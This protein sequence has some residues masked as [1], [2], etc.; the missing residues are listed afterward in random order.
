MGLAVQ[1]HRTDRQTSSTNRDQLF[2]TRGELGQ[3]DDKAG[4]AGNALSTRR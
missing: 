1:S 3:G 4:Q 2:Y